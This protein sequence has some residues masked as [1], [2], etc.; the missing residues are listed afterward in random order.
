M[1]D[2][3]DPA[4]AEE[5]ALSAKVFPDVL[6]LP[7]YD[8]RCSVEA[9][10][11]LAAGD[12]PSA[13][14]EWERRAA[15]GSGAAKCVLSLINYTENP[16]SPAELEVAKSLAREALT[17]SHRGYA[18]FLLAYYAHNEKE[19]AASAKFLG[20]ALLARFPPAFI[21]TARILSSSKSPANR[22]KAEL[23]L[24]R[25]MKLGNPGAGLVLANLAARGRFGIRK[26]IG[27]V[28]VLPVLHAKFLFEFR[29]EM[30]SHRFF[31]LN[32]G[33]PVRSRISPTVQRKPAPPGSI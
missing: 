12:L 23:L 32:F 4:D 7:L 17:S 26:L 28:L 16:S 30:F 13:M 18:N 6:V 14:L 19:Y 1:A 10:R 25:S 33:R 3:A 27:G 29:R 20:K 9:R 21:E 15:L 8:A 2:S 22:R 24:R 11:H 5:H 31:S